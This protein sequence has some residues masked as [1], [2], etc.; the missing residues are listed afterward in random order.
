[1]TVDKIVSVFK[2][3]V[4]TL[5]DGLL[6][7]LFLFLLF[8]PA[9]IKDRL[10]AAGFTKGSVAGFEWEA[11]LKAST[12][13]TKT[14][15]EAVSKADGNYQSLIDRVA[16]LET[17]VQDPSIKASLGSIGD[18]AR[19]SQSALS[20]ANQAVKRSLFAQQAIVQQVSPTTVATTGWLF[21]GKVGAD[22]TTWASGSPDTV[23]SIAPSALKAAPL[24]IHD[25]AYLRGDSGSSARSS[26]PILLVVKA[27]ESVVV[28]DIDY[29][30]AKDGGWFVWAKV[31]REP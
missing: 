14:V 22:K 25:D 24:R 4:S 31:R 18:E 20:V 10:V 27:G 19:V 29:S 17:K 1:M 6:F 12:E 2:D 23:E 28:D 15:G 21:L 30:H 7:I 13:Q 5:R 11:Q 3:L 26:A 16:E 8:A 9:T